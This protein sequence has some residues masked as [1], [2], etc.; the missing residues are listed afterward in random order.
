MSLFKDKILSQLKD[1][2]REWAYEDTNRDLD[3]FE[4]EVIVPLKHWSKILGF[5]LDPVPTHDRGSERICK[6][7]I[8]GIVTLPDND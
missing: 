3:R 2:R 4:V 1:G 5:Q 7:V 8:E 6:V